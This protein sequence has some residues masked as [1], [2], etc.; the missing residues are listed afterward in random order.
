MATSEQTRVESAPK[1]SESYNVCSVNGQ[2][3]YV[4]VRAPWHPRA[5]RTGWIHEHILAAERALGRALKPGE[6]VHHRDGNPRNNDPANIAILS[7]HAEHGRLHAQLRAQ[8]R[9]HTPP[10]CLV[11]GGTILTRRN[12]HRTFCSRKCYF[13]NLKGQPLAWRA[14]GII[15][16]LSRPRTMQ[17]GEQVQ[18]DRARRDDDHGRSLGARRTR[19]NPNNL[20]GTVAIAESTTSVA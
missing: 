2:R 6:V 18:Q 15:D 16:A 10:S 7:G 4:Q 8:A 17:H 3:G 11:C 5:W 13:A 20:S 14:H 9:G 12:Y 1:S 19:G